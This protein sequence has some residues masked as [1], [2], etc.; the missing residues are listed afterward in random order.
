MNIIDITFILII[1]I[2]LFSHFYSVNKS[3]KVKYKS[4]KQNICAKCGRKYKDNI[5]LGIC[6]DW[7]N[8]LVTNRHE[9]R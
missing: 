4:P 7:D 9:K 8:I 2:L 3:V 1:C 6:E 5:S